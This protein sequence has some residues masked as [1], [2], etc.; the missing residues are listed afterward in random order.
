MRKIIVELQME[1]EEWEDIDK[2]TCDEIILDDL[3]GI[4]E[5]FFTYSI[6]TNSVEIRNEMYADMEDK[7]WYVGEIKSCLNH[8]SNKYLI[9]RK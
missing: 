8:W 5:G 9:V 7:E 4:F 1:D 2:E 6:L 3:F